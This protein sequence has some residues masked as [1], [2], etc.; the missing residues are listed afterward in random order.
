MTL[1]HISALSLVFALVACGPGGSSE[2]TGAEN[3]AGEIASDNEVGESAHEDDE[4]ESND[5]WSDCGG[6][7]SEWDSGE[8][9]EGDDDGDG[10]WPCQ[11]RGEESCFG[12]GC[13][14]VRY[15]WTICTILLPRESPQGW[16]LASAAD[17][18]RVVKFT[19]KDDWKSIDFLAGVLLTPLA[20]GQG[21]L[22][23]KYVQL[24]E[25]FNFYDHEGEWVVS[26]DFNAN[27]TCPA[28]I[29]PEPVGYLLRER[30][31]IGAFEDLSGC[32]PDGWFLYGPD[33]TEVELPAAGPHD[34]SV[35]PNRIYGAEATVPLVS[36][37]DLSGNLVWSMDVQRG[38]AMAVAQDVDRVVLETTMGT[39]VHGSVGSVIG[40]A[41][42]GEGDFRSVKIGPNGT[43]SVA[44]EDVDGIRSAHFFTDGIHG[45]TIVLGD[46]ESSPTVVD[47]SRRGEILV[48]SYDAAE[49]RHSVLLYGREGELLWSAKLA[50]PNELSSYELGPLVA[51]FRHD[52]SGF[53]VKT[54]DG[55]HSVF[56]VSE[57]GE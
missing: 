39:I 46:I 49:Q 6:R 16:W 22:T 50:V 42:E 28:V 19:S 3:G 54:V 48:T 9:D 45:S 23:R 30:N 51:R 44:E 17:Y 40:V 52:G 26:H 25:K 31:K 35:A 15:G 27:D 33:G 2:E 41:F 7:C 10:G 24:V 57:D 5:E 53:F 38:G 43:Y 37:Y 47:V 20:T 1:R 14:L 13:E 56:E 12:T 36:L 34:L 18:S 55:H 32:D 21:Y 29:L 11:W 4:E 8:D